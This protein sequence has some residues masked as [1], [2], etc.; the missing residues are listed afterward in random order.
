MLHSEGLVQSAAAGLH[1]YVCAGCSC[2]V[3]VL[4]LP[5]APTL[6]AVPHAVLSPGYKIIFIATSQL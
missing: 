4:S 6:N 2:K 5:N 3:M 1:S